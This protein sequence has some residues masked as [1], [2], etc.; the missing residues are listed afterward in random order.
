MRHGDIVGIVVFQ[1]EGD[2][3]A[4]TGWTGCLGCEHCCEVRGLGGI[5]DCIDLDRSLVGL[6]GRDRCVDLA[7]SEGAVQY[8]EQYVCAG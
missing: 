3:Q 6:Y 4:N 2:W 1:W 7:G 8:F 5:G